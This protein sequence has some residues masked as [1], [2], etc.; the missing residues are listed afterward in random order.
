MCFEERKK[1][2][3]CVRKKFGTLDSSERAVAML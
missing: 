3:E 1:A 2:E